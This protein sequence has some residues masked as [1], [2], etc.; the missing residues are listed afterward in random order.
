MLGRRPDGRLAP[1]LPNVTRLCARRSNVLL[2]CAACVDQCS[3]LQ[4]KSL[5]V[6]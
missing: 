5:L 6:S 4:V 2:K 1:V 3:G